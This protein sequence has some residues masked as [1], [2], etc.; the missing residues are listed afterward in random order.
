M[1]KLN[2]LTLQ[3]VTLQLMTAVNHFC[4]NASRVTS[5]FAEGSFRLHVS[6]SYK[7]Y[8]ILYDSF[9]R[10]LGCRS[11]SKE[12]CVICFITSFSSRAPLSIYGAGQQDGFVQNY[13]MFWER[14]Q[15][16][17]EWN[18]VTSL[19]LT[20]SNPL[21]SRTVKALLLEINQ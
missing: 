4:S 16:C 12:L 8:F 3:C 5:H 6:C 2:L 15:I 13:R 18:S 20:I 14:M 9:W 17:F 11:L 21:S 7:D 19:L 10:K 1:C